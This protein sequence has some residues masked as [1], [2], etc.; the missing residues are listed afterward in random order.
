ML[1]PVE[2]YTSG[3]VELV[4]IDGWVTAGYAFRHLGTDG[5]AIT[6]QWIID[7]SVQKQEG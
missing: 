5:E 1:P 3:N 4:E 2:L 6:K 7:N